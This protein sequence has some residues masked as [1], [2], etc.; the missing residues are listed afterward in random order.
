MKLIISVSSRLGY[1]TA[2]LGVCC[3]TFRDCVVSSWKFELPVLRRSTFDY[4]IR[5]LFRNVV[6]QSFTVPFLFRSFTPFP[7]KA[8]IS[9]NNRRIVAIVRVAHVSALHSGDSQNCD[10]SQQHGT[11]NCGDIYHGSLRDRDFRAFSRCVLKECVH[12]SR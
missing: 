9:Y 1:C 6:H 2:A 4:G 10:H 8:A 11:H 5:T 7:Q 3:S 12:V